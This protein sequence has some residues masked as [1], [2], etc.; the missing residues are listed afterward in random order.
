M[1][2][3]IRISFG[4][5]K[6]LAT[7]TLAELLP[8]RFGPGDLLDLSCTPLLLQPQQNHIELTTGDQRI[9]W[10]L[11]SCRHFFPCL[12]EVDQVNI[13]AWWTK[14]LQSH[15]K[16]RILQPEGE[17]PFATSAVLGCCSRFIMTGPASRVL[18]LGFKDSGIS[19]DSQGVLAF[20]RITGSVDSKSA[21][22]CRCALSGRLLATGPV[23][24]SIGICTDEILP[25]HRSLLS[26]CQECMCLIC[27]LL[28]RRMQR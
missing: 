12:P 21:G 9:H 23:S 18:E 24:L 19:A 14:C 20:M 2:D 3:S 28:Q 13:K 8:Q 22:S 7:Y 27:F 16:P 15:A 6:T 25:R 1:Q 10:S 4:K 17:A 11:N 5:G 26:L